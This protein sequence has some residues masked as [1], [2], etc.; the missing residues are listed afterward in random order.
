MKI[1]NKIFVISI[2]ILSIISTLKIN[3]SQAQTSK[4]QNF[5]EVYPGHNDMS[6]NRITLGFYFTSKE[7]M[8]KRKELVEIA[9]RFN[10]A[11]MKDVPGGTENQ[12]GLFQ[13]YPFSENKNKFNILINTQNSDQL[14]SLEDNIV[15]DNFY[16]IDV[17]YVP[18]S[19]EKSIDEYKTFAY[20]DKPYTR[21]EAGDLNLSPFLAHELSH[22]IFKFDDEYAKSS[23][24]KDSLQ[25]VISKDKAESLWGKYIGKLSKSFYNFKELTKNDKK[26]EPSTGELYNPADLV[27]EESSKVA[28]RQSQCQKDGT[29][30]YT[31]SYSNLMSTVDLLYNAYQEAIAEKVLNSFTG[32]SNEIKQP[33]TPTNPTPN[34]NKNPPVE[35]ITPNKNTEVKTNSNNDSSKTTVRTGAG[36]GISLVIIAIFFTFGIVILKNRKTN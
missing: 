19:S 25:C 29:P 20:L 6:A 35:V 2:M 23:P 36:I 3:V 18:D 31:A 27:T 26:I 17:R 34:E 32:K 22:T 16:T 10:G 24:D 1:I 5:V 21:V 14:P 13:L 15:M 7:S 12:I 30:A 4:L 11:I 8:E 9:L 33:N 28:I